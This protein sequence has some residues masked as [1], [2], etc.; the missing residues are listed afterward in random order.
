[1]SQPREELPIEW[2]DCS[3][4]GTPSVQRLPLIRPRLEVAA[5]LRTPGWG[6]RGLVED[7]ICRPLHANAMHGCAI[8][9]DVEAR[10]GGVVKGGGQRVVTPPRG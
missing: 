7:S 2:H 1:M 4:V 9:T 3:Y 10:R 8:M 6:V 5:E